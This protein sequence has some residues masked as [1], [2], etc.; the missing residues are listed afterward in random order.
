MWCCLIRENIGLNLHVVSQHSNRLL[1][2][3]IPND[4]QLN[5]RTVCQCD[6]SACITTALVI[7][8]QNNKDK[9]IRRP[10]NAF[11]IFSKR[12]RPLVH[13]RHPNQDNRTVSKIL[14]EWWYALDPNDRSKYEQLA[15]QVNNLYYLYGSKYQFLLIFFSL[16]LNQYFRQPTKKLVKFLASRS[17][18][19]WAAVESYQTPRMEPFHLD[20][21]PGKNEEKFTNIQGAWLIYVDTLSKNVLL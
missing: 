12:H 18:G 14:G 8:L 16:L 10:M 3:H 2:L 7:P 17:S 19:R 1:L 6:T 21:A 13:Q 15:V 11:M 5:F 20:T 4:A 9:T